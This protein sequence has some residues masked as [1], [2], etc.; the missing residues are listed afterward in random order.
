MAVGGGV[1]TFGSWFAMTT[2]G[3][4][5]GVCTGVIRIHSTQGHC[6]LIRKIY[7]RFDKLIS[8]EER[9][10]VFDLVF[11]RMQAM[12]RAIFNRQYILGK[13][14]KA[15]GETHADPNLASEFLISDK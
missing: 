11:P 5:S 10:H 1:A 2:V 13:N 12:T 7:S 8:K 15:K 4:S 14:S 9:G 6:V 3:E